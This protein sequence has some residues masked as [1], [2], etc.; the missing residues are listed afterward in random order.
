MSTGAS[1]ERLAV[2]QDAAGSSPVAPAN[3]LLSTLLSMH[4]F[5]PRVSQLRSRSAVG[6][7]CSFAKKC[8]TRSPSLQNGVMIDLF[9]RCLRH[10][11][12]CTE[13]HS[14]LIALTLIGSHVAAPGVLF[15]GTRLTA[16]IGLLDRHYYLRRAESHP[17]CL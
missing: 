2:T 17:N 3:S 13:R 14:T 7:M 15:V 12:D 5:H 1:L 10:R 4:V 16:L 6:I 8:E 9:T 11:I